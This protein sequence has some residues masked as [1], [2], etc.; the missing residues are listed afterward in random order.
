M[1]HVL[2]MLFQGSLGDTLKRT[3]TV[4]IEANDDPYGYFVISNL[5]RPISVEETAQGTDVML[6]VVCCIN[7]CEI[8]EHVIV[9]SLLSASLFSASNLFLFFFLYY[10]VLEHIK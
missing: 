5:D 1:Q 7:S 9:M 2:F 4:T 6:A 8:V 3:A 10:G